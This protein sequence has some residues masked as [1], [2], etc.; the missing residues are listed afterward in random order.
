M[1]TPRALSL[2]VLC[3]EVLEHLE[4]PQELVAEIY[5]VLKHG[6]GGVITVPWSVRSHY[7]PYDYYRFTPD[8]LTK[9]FHNF[10][11]YKIVPRGTDIAVV[12]SK[13]IVIYC[14]SVRFSE[15]VWLWP[16]KLI[17]AIALLPLVALV[18]FIGHLSLFFRIGSKDD[19]LGY[20]VW[21]EKT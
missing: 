10:S 6:A 12:A 7:I 15:K 21:L 11:S 16:A 8:A 19:P 2:T 18:V 17:I 5:R 14:W 9:L 13:I 1:I 4:E 3:T 20:T